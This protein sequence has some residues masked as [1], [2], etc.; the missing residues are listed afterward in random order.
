MCPGKVLL[1]KQASAVHAHLCMD[2][3]YI[4]M[5]MILQVARKAPQSWLLTN[6]KIKISAKTDVSCLLSDVV[7][8]KLW[9]HG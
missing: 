4:Q 2:N 7:R 3:I 5:C 9:M 6:Q 8:N 1:F